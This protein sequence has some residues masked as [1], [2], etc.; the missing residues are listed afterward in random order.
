MVKADISSCFPSIYTHALSWALATKDTAK[1]TRNND[2]LWYNKIDTLTRKLTNDETHG[3]LIGPHVSNLLAEIILTC[4][5]SKLQH[6]SYVR[7]I[8]DYTCYVDS[9]EDGQRFLTELGAALREYDLSL[10][11]KKLKYW[12]CHSQQLLIGSVN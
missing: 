2:S 8:D 4:V 1:A 7:A 9:H 5:D 6:W 10:N 12:N 11:H 3:L